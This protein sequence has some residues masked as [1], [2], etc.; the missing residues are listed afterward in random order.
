MDRRPLLFEPQ[1]CA[2]AI[3]LVWSR[4]SW[5]A[6]RDNRSLTHVTL[7]PKYASVPRAHRPRDFK[8]GAI[9]KLIFYLL[10]LF[11]NSDFVG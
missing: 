1:S 3:Q 8:S 10:I 2:P 4:Q 6:L 7:P 5:S 11:T 9:R